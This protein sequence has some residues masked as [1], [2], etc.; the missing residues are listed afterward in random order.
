MYCCQFDVHAT[1]ELKFNFIHIYPVYVILKNN[2][3]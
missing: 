1:F 3:K 2:N